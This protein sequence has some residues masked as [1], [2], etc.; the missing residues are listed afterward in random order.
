MYPILKVLA[1][2]PFYAGGALAIWSLT[3]DVRVLLAVLKGDDR[4]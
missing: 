1:Y 2:V 4:A 3:R